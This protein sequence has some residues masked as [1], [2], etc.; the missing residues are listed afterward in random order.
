MASERIRGTGLGLVIDGVDYFADAVAV[1]LDHDPLE[2]DGSTP[3]SIRGP[4]EIAGRWY[5]DVTAIQSTAPT[6]LWSLLWAYA[7]TPAGH[8]VPFTYAPHGNE[9]PTPERPHFV[10]HLRLDSAPALGGTAG[11]EVEYVFTKRLWTT[12][13]RPRRIEAPL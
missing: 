8:E 13:G 12:D 7:G 10:G 9:V 1:V 11:T 4:I 5:V 3:C 6:S 2:V